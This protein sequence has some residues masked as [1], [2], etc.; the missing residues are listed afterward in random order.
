MLSSFIEDDPSDS[1]RGDV[2][3]KAPQLMITAAVLERLTVSDLKALL[4]RWQGDGGSF[5]V[6]VLLPEAECAKVRLVQAVCAEVGCAVAGA[7]FPSLIV[8]AAFRESGAVLLRVDNAPLPLLL[9]EAAA[10]DAP[11][12]FGRALVR[13]VEANV[14]DDEDAALFC[15]FDAL[16]PN[17]AT[18]LDQWYLQLANRV[19]YCGVNAGNERFAPAPCLFDAQ[20]FV[21]N[22]A[23]VQ[24][25]PG[26]PGAVLEHGYQVPDHLIMATSAQGNRI[27]HIDWR[28]ALAIYRELLADA[29]GVEVTL[30]SFY[31]HAVHFPFG[32]LRADSEVLVRIPTTFDADGAIVC[33]GE[34]PAN[35]LLAL[36]DARG[37]ADRAVPALQMAL[38]RLVAAPIEHLLLFYCA[39]RRLHVGPL[40]LTEIAALTHGGEKKV[41]G[42]LSLGEIGT[43]PSG[44]HPLFHNAALVGMP[45]PGR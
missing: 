6:V 30:E 39:G 15:V 43:A 17:I 40:A 13:Y 5:H 18:H 28:P 8:G 4:V 2:R 33:A 7:L 21:A 31:S 23:L 16:V 14:A 10:A 35:S 26:H 25:L 32:I 19:E 24:L 20:H 36:L 29:Y 3:G 9:T 38:A 42:A 34:I 41:I 11:Q 44:G 45:W 27:L 22:G 1:E 12:R 37:C